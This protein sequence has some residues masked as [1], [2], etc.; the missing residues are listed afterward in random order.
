VHIT[1]RVPQHLL[2]AID[3]A[4]ANS[5]VTRSRWIK[6]T[7]RR[8]IAVDAGTTPIDPDWSSIQEAIEAEFENLAEPLKG[9]KELR[10]LIESVLK[11]SIEAVM[12]GRQ[13]ALLHSPAVLEQ[14]QG[15]T[16]DYY[17]TLR[18]FTPPERPTEHPGSESS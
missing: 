1:L 8:A 7:A 6:E 9:V 17:S 2:R 12:I 11:L 13:L 10:L 5:A 16:R 15:L 14:A 18:K 3:Q 4:A